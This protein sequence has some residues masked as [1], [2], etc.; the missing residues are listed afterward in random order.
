M[1]KPRVILT[2][3]VTTLMSAFASA[4]EHNGVKEFAVPV[5]KYND[6]EKLLV[7]ES[8]GRYAHDLVRKPYMNA[9]EEIQA[10]STTVYA[11]VLDKERMVSQL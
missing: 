1:I 11:G 4:A 6:K 9:H 5:E 2:L 7:C 3:W 8:D 10:F